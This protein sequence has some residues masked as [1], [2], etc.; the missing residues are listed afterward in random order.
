MTISEFVGQFFFQNNS[1]QLQEVFSKLGI[2]EFFKNELGNFQTFLV[3]Q[4]QNQRNH[5]YDNFL[6]ISCCTF[7]KPI[8]EFSVLLED[9]L[10]IISGT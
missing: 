3:S 7:P 5:I 2:R 10:M 6:K 1:F 8:E 4:T 9:S